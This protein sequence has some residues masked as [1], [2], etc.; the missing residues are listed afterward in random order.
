MVNTSNTM[1]YQVH[2]TKFV[3]LRPL[4]PK[5]ACEVACQLMDIFALLAA[6]VIL[7]T[8]NGSEFTAAIITELK[9]CHWVD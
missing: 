2:L 3:V 9:R 7:Q 4:T 8:D 1:V 6:P 5:R